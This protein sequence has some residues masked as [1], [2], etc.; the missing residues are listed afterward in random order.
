MKHL[1]IFTG[2]SARIDISWSKPEK[3]FN[4]SRIFLNTN[5]NLTLNDIVPAIY[6]K[7]FLNEEEN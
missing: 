1:L 3:S 4:G 5:M 2:H 6:R 7:C